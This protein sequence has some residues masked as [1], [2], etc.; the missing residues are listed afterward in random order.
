MLST[1][2]LEE[3]SNCRSKKGGRKAEGSEALGFVHS[4]CQTVA[5]QLV[6]KLL[7]AVHVLHI[8]RHVSCPPGLRDSDFG[9]QTPP[10][11]CLSGTDFV[12]SL[13]RAQRAQLLPP[14]CHERKGLVPL[15]AREHLVEN[16]T[17]SGHY[18]L[19][20]HR[21]CLAAACQRLRQ[22]RSQLQGLQANAAGRRRKEAFCGHAVLPRLAERLAATHTPRL[23]V[24]DVLR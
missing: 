15:A 5:H 6:Y 2:E 22:A 1:R 12:R 18:L 11:P 14:P 16:V 20:W 7:H 8:I 4:L 19:R 17:K 13:T 10:D 3:H 21:C 23:H 9:W 24:C